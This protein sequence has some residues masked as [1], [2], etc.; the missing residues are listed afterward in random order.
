MKENLLINPLLTMGRPMVHLG[1][2]FLHTRWANKT[3]GSF[4]ADSTGDGLQACS[5][6]TAPEAIPSELARPLGL[7]QDI[8]IGMFLPIVLS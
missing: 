5:A 3:E 7:V 1:S 2:Q 4:G 8:W 6:R